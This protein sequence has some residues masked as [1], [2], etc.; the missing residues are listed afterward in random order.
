VTAERGLM[1]GTATAE[2]IGWAAAGNCRSTR[3]CI[4]IPRP[5]AAFTCRVL[6]PDDAEFAGRPVRKVIR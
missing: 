2:Q 4:L 1:A 6:A 5:R 3:V